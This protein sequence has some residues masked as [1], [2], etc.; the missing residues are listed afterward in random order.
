MKAAAAAAVA[1]G[2]GEATAAAAPTLVLGLELPSRQQRTFQVE[3]FDSPAVAVGVALLGEAAAAAEPAAVV[4]LPAGS[5]VADGL[6]AEPPAAS[7]LAPHPRLVS[8]QV[9]RS[10]NG[11]A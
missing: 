3:D 9:A 2:T 4:V 6:A 5:A 7:Q 8:E 1:G 10:A 11:A